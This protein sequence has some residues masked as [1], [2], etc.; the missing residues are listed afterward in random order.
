MK[1]H[2]IVKFYP[3]GVRGPSSSQFHRSCGELTGSFTSSLAAKREV[4][5]E[6]IP[7]NNLNPGNRIYAVIS[8]VF[9]NGKT[10]KVLSGRQISF[11][12]LS[13]SIDWKRI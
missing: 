10:V 7:H 2:F 3:A 11:S 6:M 9:P 1:P 8:K 13:S 4:E 5:S 12:G